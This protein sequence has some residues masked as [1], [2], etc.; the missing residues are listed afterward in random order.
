MV[1]APLILFMTPQGGTAATASVS[2]GNAA[3]D[4]LL[5]ARSN[6]GLQNLPADGNAALAAA[7][8]AVAGDLGT[9]VTSAPAVAAANLPNDLSSRLAAVLQ[10]EHACDAITAAAMPT[11]RASAVTLGVDKLTVAQATIDALRACAQ[12]LYSDGIALSTFAGSLSRSASRSTTIQALDVWPVINLDLSGGT[13]TYPWDYVLIV[14]NNNATFLNNAGG[15]LIDVKRSPSNSTMARGCETVN[16]F[17]LNQDPECIPASAVLIQLAGDNAFEQ[18]QAPGEDAICTS[19]PVVRRIV[20]EGAAVAGVG[21]LINSSTGTNS[22]HAK[23]SSQGAGHIGGIGILDATGGTNSFEAIRNAQGFGFIGGLGLFHLA[24]TTNTVTYTPMPSGGI[25]DDTG[26]CNATTKHLQGAGEAGGVGAVV[27]DSGAST[28]TSNTTQAQG[29]GDLVLPATQSAG[30]GIGI[31][32]AESRCGSDGYFG[33]PGR[34]NGGGLIVVVGPRA[35][36]TGL[37]DFVDIRGVC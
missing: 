17:L 6:P 10:D 32:L 8:D 23:T 7:I 5:A 22:Y 1:V 30:P 2:T 3:I 28:W 25:I 36:L 34:T 24:A 33:V 29:T 31:F 35:D 27:E 18:T 12:T 21:L 20:T 37:D 19:A 11:I 14:D 26:V 4:G 16:D 9:S 15:N 13:R